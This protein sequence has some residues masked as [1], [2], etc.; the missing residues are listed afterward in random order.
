[1][2]E[3]PNRGLGFIVGP[4]GS[5]QDYRSHPGRGVI[6]PALFNLYNDIPGLDE[7]VWYFT[8]PNRGFPPFLD[9]DGS[10][11]G[12]KSSVAGGGPAPTGVC[13]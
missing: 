6:P 4:Y 12:S 8:A 1:M 3:V 2:M 13:R 5:E 11:R 9:Q 10:G 7:I